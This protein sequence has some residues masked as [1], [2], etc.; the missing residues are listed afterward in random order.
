MLL[1]G[2]LGSGDRLLCSLIILSKLFLLFP[3][4]IDLLP[5]PMDFLIDCLPVL[6]V[7]EDFGPKFFAFLD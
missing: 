6:I 4:S 5:Q 1:E 2:A 7:L 3:Q